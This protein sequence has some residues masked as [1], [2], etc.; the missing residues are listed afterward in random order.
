VLS[1]KF[2]RVH[3][4]FDL[5]QVPSISSECREHAHKFLQS[6]ED[7]ELW[8]LKRKSESSE[9]YH[10]KIKTGSFA[11]SVH[12]ATARFTSGLLNGNVNQ[13]GDFD[14]CVDAR[15]PNNEF[16]GKYCL[17]YLQ[18][19]VPAPLKYTNYLRRLLQSHDAFKSTF[20]DVSSD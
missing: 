16:R 1:E 19:S 3:R 12:D 17:A 8:A 5:S 4:P 20:D 14:Q 2:L 18:P 10:Q 7:F 13:L 11:H 9:N 6:L 15:E